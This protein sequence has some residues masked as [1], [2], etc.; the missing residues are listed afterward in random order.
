MQR[1]EE[2][3]TP[4]RYRPANGWL[5]ARLT[6]QHFLTDQQ[7]RDLLC[8]TLARVFLALLVG[9][10]IVAASDPPDLAAPLANLAFWQVI[11]TMLAVIFGIAIAQRGHYEW[12]ALIGVVSLWLLL[13]ADAIAGD[14]LHND[15]IGAVSLLIALSGMVLA[16]IVSNGLTGASILLILGLWQ[17][18]R[19]GLLHN[20]FSDFHDTTAVDQIVFVSVAGVMV[21]FMSTQAA[22]V[23]SR[24]ESLFER[25][26]L[27]MIQ[28]TLDGQMMAINRRFGEM[29]DRDPA[30]MVGTNYQDLLHPDERPAFYRDNIVMRSEAGGIVTAERRYIRHDGS[31]MWAG[32]TAV[33]VPDPQG[34]KPLVLAFVQDISERR[35]AEDALRRSEE[36]FRALIEHSAD[37]IAVIAPDG[38]V[39]YR[40]PSGGTALGLTAQEADRFSIFSRI[41]PDEVQRVQQEFAR[42]VTTPGGTVAG[43]SRL[44]HNNGSWRDFAWTVRNAI[45]IQGVDG[46]IMNA[47]DETLQRSLEEQLQQARKMEAIGH[48]AGGI[49]HDFNNILGAILGFADLLEQDLPSGSSGRRY[50]GRIVAAGHRARGLVQQILA[51]ARKSDLERVPTDL[52]SIVGEVHDLLQVSLPATTEFTLVP[53]PEPLTAIVNA[54]QI[55]QILINLCLNA[56]DA[57]MGAPGRV[58]LGIGRE[59]SPGSGAPSDAAAGIVTT[60]DLDPALEYARIEVT[61]TGSGMDA[62]TLQQIFD[63]FFTTKRRDRGTGLGLAVV[64]GIVADY[65]GI[66]QVRSRPGAGTSFAVWMPLAEAPSTAEAAPLPAETSGNERILIV[67]DEPAL[68]EVLEIGLTRLGY[69][70][71][72]EPDPLEALKR[73]EADPESIDVVISDHNMPKLTGFALLE[74]V[75]QLRPS[76]K[77]I[78]CTGFSE[79]TVEAEAVAAGVDGFF[80]KPVQPELLA[81][82]IRRLSD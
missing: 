37:I 49:A 15:S 48:L 61:D 34:E 51:F 76:V 1:G 62:Q 4:A 36:R 23:K 75:K 28:G 8:R 19:S 80:I 40:S 27:G 35:R 55:S 17:A 14:G 54:S 25:A 79:G 12:A 29:L 39:R 58:T 30:Q 16:P 7:A 47:R 60:G 31:V 53:A 45:D 32:I 9:L 10:A 56:N 63:P 50:A 74:R 64:H 44:R 43:R 26:P 82:Q 72:T 21:H 46:M 71:A 52:G 57:L 68:R 65:G 6:P 67:D 59:T 70:V 18:E 3:R 78:L 13:A 2:R 20:R 24:L 69:A 77:F 41:H 42:L 5:V 81:A 66:C 73:F 22:R 11:A 33:R 38:H